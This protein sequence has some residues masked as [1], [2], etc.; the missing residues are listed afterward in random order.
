VS[1]ISATTNPAAEK[2]PRGRGEHLA[3]L[4]LEYHRAFA[5][6][7]VAQINL[8]LSARTKNTN[9]RPKQHKIVPRFMPEYN[10]V[11]PVLFSPPQVL[12]PRSL[13]V[14]VQIVELALRGLRRLV[15]VCRQLQRGV[16]PGGKRGF[17]L[18]DKHTHYTLKRNQ[19][20]PPWPVHCICTILHTRCR[21]GTLRVFNIHA[22]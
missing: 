3:S 4:R 9:L 10:R 6:A 18:A 14:K 8:P 15:L 11:Y 12:R 1:G 22:R 19:E 21:R 5:R 20:S 17:N 16:V 2:L 13:R 7:L